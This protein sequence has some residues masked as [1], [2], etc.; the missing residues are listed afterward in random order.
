MLPAGEITEQAVAQLG[1]LLDQGDTVIDGGNTFYKDDIRR[2]QALKA[3]GIHYVDCGT[4]GGVWGLERGYCMMI[5]GDKSVVGALD[6]L[7]D[8]LAPGAGTI[9]PTPGREGRDPRV[10]RGYLHCGPAGAGHF[11]KMI[12]NGIEYG[13]MQ[14]FAEGFNIL[15]GAASDKLPEEQ[16]YDF[17]LPDIAE[18]WRRGS[19]V[20]SWLLDLT[21]IALAQDPEL[22][23]YSGFVEDSGEGRWT[24]M[25]A[26]EEA[27]PGPCSVRSPLCALSIARRGR[28]FGQG[29]VGYAAPVRRPRRTEEPRLMAE[30]AR[31]AQRISSDAE[32]L[33][34]DAAEWLCGL[35]LNSTGWLSVCCSGGST[36]KRL[37]ELLAEP[38]M[39]A[40]FPWTRVHWFWGDE[41]FVPRDHPDSNYR[42][43]HEAMLSRVNVPDGNVHPVQTHLPSPELAAAAYEKTLKE[44]YGAV[45]LDPARPLF[46]VTLLGI[47]ED[48]H[49]ASLFP[50]HSATR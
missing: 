28:L 34:R 47:G 42:A 15:R 35:A 7:F 45:E 14:A 44:F 27:V 46:D 49:T 43:T 13:L 11:V 24:I 6:P 32:A 2:A 41:R 10:E 38:E 5:G 12:H 26:I 1:E 50:G 9:P 48:G 17:D 20:G 8:A 29:P 22:K 37:Y 33:A 16:R 25:A 30:A 36:P 19:V 21:A 3:K 18:V 40:R 31:V 4:S 39:A 23:N